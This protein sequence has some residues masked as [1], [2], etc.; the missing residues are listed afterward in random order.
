MP[1]RKPRMP[2]VEE[3]E[4]INRAKQRDHEAWTL[5]QA[6]HKERVFNLALRMMGD[7]GEAEDMT[8]DA[9]VQAW[10]GIP[11]F[12]GNAQLSTWLYR[13]VVNRCRN[14]LKQLGKHGETESLDEPVSED[15]HLTRGDLLA[16]SATPQTALERAELHQLV[17]HELQ[18]LPLDFRTVV[19]LRDIEGLSYRE[20][21]EVTGVSL[22][23]VK[24]RLFRAR[25]ELRERLRPHLFPGDR[26]AN[27]PARKWTNKILTQLGVA[28]L[29]PVEA[30]VE[31]ARHASE[32][33]PE[34][35]DLLDRHLRDLPQVTI[36][37]LHE[38]TPRDLSK[39]RTVIKTALLTS[40]RNGHAA[41]DETRTKA[42][43]EPPSPAVAHRA[44]IAPSLRMAGKPDAEIEAR[45][46]K[47][48]EKP[49]ADRYGYLAMH[50]LDG[51]T[52]EEIALEKKV[53]LAAVKSGLRD[54]IVS[55]VNNARR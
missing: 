38:L 34:L 25:S 11:R 46:R 18:G 22:E 9:F 17:H 54:A 29:P 3:A 53:A 7:Y 51:K 20:M 30:R 37:A 41:T 39:Q 6:R 48:L 43:P 26:P 27:D 45:I 19:H 47:L 10:A 49:R 42:E 2:A 24:S 16:D 28:H 4:L 35:Q 14:R 32:L 40:L 55:L 44:G 23:A 31:V 33:D 52:P 1:P 15:E 12:K 5:L 8:Q 21:A 50:Y 36:L 13:I